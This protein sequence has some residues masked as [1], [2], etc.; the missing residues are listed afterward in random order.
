[1]LGAALLPQVVDGIQRNVMAIVKHFILNQQELD[2]GSVNEI[3]D[4][5]LIMELYGPP[6]AAAV[7]GVDGRQAAGVMW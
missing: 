7:A 6:F 4:E 3:A 2:R 5:T 1:M